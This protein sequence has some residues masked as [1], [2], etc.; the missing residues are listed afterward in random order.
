M[1]G[2]PSH[3]C[4]TGTILNTVTTPPGIPAIEALLFDLGG[5]V[6]GFDFLRAFER[7]AELSG[8]GIKVLAASF[9]FDEAYC[10]HETGEITASDYFESLRG[11]LGI[12]LSDEQFA[13]GWNRIF[14]GPIPGIERLLNRMV[15]RWPLYAFTNSNPTHQRFW[16]V[17]Y[18]AMLSVF[19]TIFVSSE[20][21]L[22][23]P[24][25]RSFETVAQKIGVAPERILFF[26]D[27]PTNIHG[28]V[29]AGLVAA[30][31]TS[32]ADV[33]AAITQANL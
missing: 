32:A 1:S 10:Q 17:E 12:D 4:H 20:L 26:D 30:H 13:S 6:I 9:E 33:E 28:A 19:R 25:P 27:S 11:S 31:V 24:E 21:G 23:K 7:W 18:S 29:E 15:D 8:S 2:S 5:V 14:L 16:S 22:R 3:L